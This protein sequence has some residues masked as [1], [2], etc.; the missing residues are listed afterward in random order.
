MKKIASNLTAL[1]IGDAYVMEE[2]GAAKILTELSTKQLD[3]SLKD[4]TAFSFTLDSM[5]FTLFNTGSGSFA[6]RTI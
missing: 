2:D 3:F 4:A 5:H 6:V 1:D